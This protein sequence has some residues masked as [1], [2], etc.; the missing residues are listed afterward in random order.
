MP[1]EPETMA[2]RASSAAR[3]FYGRRKGHRLSARRERLLET[4]LPRLAV[5]LASP[6]PGPLTALFDPPVRD[7]WLEIGFGAGEHLAWQAARNRDIGF[8][9]C[10]PFVNGLAAMLAEIE[11]AKLANLRLHGDDGR[12]V[13]AWLPAASLGR[14]FV[15]FPDPWPKKRHRRRRLIAAETLDQIARVLR[16][17]G[18][19]RLA[20]D[21]PD[22]AAA[23]LG[24][25]SRH[26]G[27]EWTAR[28]PADWRER[29]AD[30]PATRYEEKARAQG[31]RPYFLVFR[32]L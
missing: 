12:D 15:L 16:A 2:D 3:R 24:A 28:R 19:L 22:Y 20:S 18:E 13:L 7:V 4:L 27:F 8:I 1:D 26:G 9:G 21:D 10:E 29:R 17:G 25:A 31:R 32:R 14:V 6:A 23:M 11:E 30:W 5:D